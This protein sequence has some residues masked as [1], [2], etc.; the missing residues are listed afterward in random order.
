VGEV[1]RKLEPLLEG[2]VAERRR[3]GTYAMC[4]ARINSPITMA[5]VSRTVA[6]LVLAGRA[7]EKATN[8][9]ALTGAMTRPVLEAAGEAVPSLTHASGS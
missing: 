1:R 9:D 7:I 8:Q 2:K 6:S 3:D 5:K 4:E